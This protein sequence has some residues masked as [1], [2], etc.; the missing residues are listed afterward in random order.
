MSSNVR[1]IIRM[2]ENSIN[3][4]STST[5]R[6]DSEAIFDHSNN[7]DSDSDDSTSLSSEEGEQQ[8][9]NIFLFQD[10]FS[11]LA[12]PHGLLHSLQRSF[13]DLTKPDLSTLPIQPPLE[14]AICLD[15]FQGGVQMEQLPC[16]HLFHQ[17]CI[18]EH[19]KQGNDQCPICRA[20]LGT[21]LVQG[22]WERYSLQ[23]STTAEKS[24]DKH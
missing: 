9:N 4:H 19:F 20:D 2:F 5:T 23:M 11:E 18:I 12:Y 13:L 15:Q 1:N 10:A 6:T 17:S 21:G 14:C 24:G 8:E 16:W 3:E 7:T 22:Y